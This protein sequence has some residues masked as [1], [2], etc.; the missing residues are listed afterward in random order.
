MKLVTYIAMSIII[1]ACSNSGTNDSSP[2]VDTWLTQACAQGTSSSGSPVNEWFIGRY[3]FTASGLLI[4]E[5][6]QY[7]DSQCVTKSESQTIIHTGSPP[8]YID[9]DPTILQ[10]GI[11]GHMITIIFQDPSNNYSFDGFYTINNNVLCF[12]EKFTFEPLGFGA[13]SSGSDAIDFNECLV[14]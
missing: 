5:P 13:E 12:S 10:E 14:K 11:Q 8:S 2:L 1:T 4:F 6:D 9:V 3:E 7:E